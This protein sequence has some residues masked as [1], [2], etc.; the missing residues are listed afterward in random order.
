VSDI[1]EIAR[2][3]SEGERDALIGAHRLSDFSDERAVYH[4]CP[5]G[6][7]DSLFDAGLIRGARY[8]SSLGMQVR[9]HLTQ[10]PNDG[11]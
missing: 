4:L 11:R 9:A 7:L 5:G 3:L 1:G 6:V 10:E 2:G 8:V